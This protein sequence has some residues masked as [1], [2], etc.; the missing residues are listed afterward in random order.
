[1]DASVCMRLAGEQVELLADRAMYWPARGRLLIADLHLGKADTYRRAGIALPRGGTTR[2]LDRLSQLVAT[3][4]A[5]QL[6]VLGDLLHGPLVDTHWRDGWNAWRARHV[7]LDVA[8]LAGNHDRAL[9]TAGLA[10]DLLGTEMDEAP[11][12]LRH[13]PQVHAHLHVLCGHVHPVAALP[14]L[15]GQFPAFWLRHGITV[16][17]AFSAFTGGFAARLS[18]GE[19]LAICTEGGIVVAKA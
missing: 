15:R 11:F 18:S 9:A 14:G 10:V 19:G 16:L 6:W 13:A 17:P 7:A 3:T 2:D 8:V 12:A 1:V 4:G 5:R